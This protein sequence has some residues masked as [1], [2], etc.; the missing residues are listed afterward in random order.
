[1]NVLGGAIMVNVPD[2]D[3]SAAFMIDLLGFTETIT[4]DGLAVIF[5]AE[6]DLHIA[7]LRVGMQDFKPESVAGPLTRGMII[8]MVVTGVDA[9]YDR[10]RAAG[11][12][13]V[14]PLDYSE[15]A[16]NSGERYFQMRDPNGIIVRLTEWV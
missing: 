2:P 7:Y 9:E 10:L 16:E 13:I 8:V 12:E 4:D 3:A 5:S 14:T 15:W 11:A 6:A 1:M